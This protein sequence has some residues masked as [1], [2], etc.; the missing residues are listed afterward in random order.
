M[1]QWRTGAFALEGLKSIGRYQVLRQLGEGGMGQVFLARDPDLDRD[2]ALKLLHGHDDHVKRERFRAEARSIAA[3]RHAGIVTIYEIAEHDGRQFLAME[4]LPGRSMRE[5]L[6]TGEETATLLRICQRVVEAVAAAHAQGILHRDIK[7]ENVVVSDDTVKV[8]DFGLARKLD[9]PSRV[10]HVG[11]STTEQRRAQATAA[12]DVFTRTLVDDVSATQDSAP[13]AT[14]HT[15]YGTPA[16]MAPEVLTGEPATPASDAYALG[17]ML[18]ECIAGRRPFTGATMYELIA[19][20]IDGDAPAPL[21]HSLGALVAQL[22]DRDPVNRPQLDDVEDQLRAFVLRTPIVPIRASADNLKRRSVPGMIE[23]ATTARVPRRRRRIGWMLAAAVAVGGGIAIFVTTRPGAVEQPRDAT[24]IRVAIQDLEVSLPSYGSTVNFIAVT[25]ALGVM[26]GQLEKVEVVDLHRLRGVASDAD[27]LHSAADA[28]AG[29]LVRGKI[30]EHDDRLHA[31]FEILDPRS[32]AATRL[33]VPDV[34]A[35]ESG[36]LLVEIANAIV[37]R[38]DPARTPLTKGLGRG[39]ALYDR[40]RQAYEKTEWN[41]ARP[42]LEASVYLDDSSFDACLTLALVRDWMG[43][44][45]DDV[46]AALLQA[47]QNKPENAG[48][49]AQIAEGLKHYVRFHYKDAIA[50]LAPIA[51]AQDLS[52]LE[53]TELSYYLGEAY[54]HD[55]QH[56]KGRDYLAAAA[57]VTELNGSRTIAFKPAAIHCAEYA[58]ARRQPEEALKY[59]A[60][61]DQIDFAMRDYARVA[62][63]STQYGYHAKVVLG[64]VKPGEEASFKNDLEAHDWLTALAIE[65][66]DLATARAEAA[67]TWTEIEKLPTATTIYSL[68]NFGE[69]LL[70]RP[71]LRDDIERLLARH[72]QMASVRPRSRERFRLLAAPILGT[73]PSRTP[74]FT[75]RMSRLA[76]AVD[77]E[78]AGDHAKAASILDE[79]IADPTSSWDFPE[80]VAL[81]RNLVALGDR[82]RIDVVCAE[83]VEPAL[84]RPALVTARASCRDAGYKNLRKR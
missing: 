36:R 23:A 14:K 57:S 58:I 28:G 24:A 75:T 53:Q 47:L 66:D 37:Q 31:A 22:L 55:G 25:D 20:V 16:Y 72:E 18:Y 46:M 8:V 71:I 60:L 11:A 70:S 34:P 32:G 9:A 7:P 80:R 77:A 1:R 63:R 84:G 13:V 12:V 40:G 48:V 15:I 54:W 27:W 59:E 5:L 51:S 29:Y 79:L 81:L 43:S 83:I 17:V 52:K 69:M 73:K 49:R 10:D 74:D 62:G 42:F 2:V 67:K 4:Y 19:N 39:R 61:P 68:E 6:E 76:D 65:R 78:I 3:L 41:A 30:S 82:K 56:T 33:S 50:V 45:P 21:E 64:T 44:T 38:T 26:I 35:N